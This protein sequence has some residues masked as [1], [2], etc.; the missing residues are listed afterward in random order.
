G[1]NIGTTITAYL[2]SLGA[3]SNAKRASYAHMLINVVGVL[4]I[5][6]IFA[7]YIKV[8]AWFVGT[9][10]GTAVVIDGKTTYPFI[11]RGVN[12]LGVDSQNYPMDKRVAI[13]NKIAD[14]WKLDNF[15]LLCSEIS[16][17]QLSENIDLILEGKQK[18][19]VLVNLWK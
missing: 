5:T 1:E 11:L 14:E 15:E 8:V 6:A 7:F 16:L 19:R 18:G 3:C 17:E 10:P 9:D 2:A 4:W 12:L 13:W